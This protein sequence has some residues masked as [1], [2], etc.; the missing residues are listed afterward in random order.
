ME[1][2]ILSNSDFAALKETVRGELNKLRHLQNADK[3]LAALDGLNQAI[4]EKTAQAEKLKNHV[5]EA[6]SVKQAAND[7]ANELRKQASDEKRAADKHK[8]DMLAQAE[9]DAEK[10]KA[11]ARAEAKNELAASEK[12][13]ADLAS[14][15]EELA[16]KN[17]DAAKELEAK[18][19]E[20][21]GLNAEIA[22]IKATAAAFLK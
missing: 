8:A 3:A 7:Y 19:K 5:A 10:I 11:D 21:E 17:V 9:K 20:L 2:P 16:E 15:G 22:K 14:K 18:K 4:A 6:E 13:V 1:N 12:L